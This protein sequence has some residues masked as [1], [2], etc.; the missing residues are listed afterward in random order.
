[1]RDTCSRVIWLRKGSIQ[2]VGSPDEV[3]SSYQHSVG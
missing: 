3:V 1:M 2:L